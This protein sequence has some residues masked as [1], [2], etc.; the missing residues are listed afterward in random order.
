MTPI[1]FQMIMSI[2][3]IALVTFA[4]TMDKNAYVEE[5]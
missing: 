3:L 5:F 4:Y 2:A 1:D